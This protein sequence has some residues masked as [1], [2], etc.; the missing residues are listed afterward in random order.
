MG[1]SHEV[2]DEIVHARLG[3]VDVTSRVE[4][5]RVTLPHEVADDAIADVDGI[6]AA[7]LVGAAV[8]TRGVLRAL[9]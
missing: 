4:A 1:S 9:A 2:R 3:L 8:V 7:D 5:P 6:V